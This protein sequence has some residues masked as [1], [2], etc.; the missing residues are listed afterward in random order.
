MTTLMQAVRHNIRKRHHP[1]PT[2]FALAQ[3][4]PASLNDGRVIVIIDRNYRAA[5]SNG[6]E[7]EWQGTA[8]TIS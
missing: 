1:A 2:A 4:P 8:N 7:W 3:V 6:I 5:V